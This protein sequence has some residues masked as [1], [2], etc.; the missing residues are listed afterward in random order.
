MDV[1]IS[2]KP[3]RNKKKVY[4][5]LEWGKGPGER[6]ATGIYSWN[7][8]QNQIEKNY[9]KEALAIL[10]T[11]KAEMVLDLQAAGSVH[12]RQHKIK[13]NFLDYY[14][15]HIHR[16]PS[17]IKKTCRFLVIRQVKF[18]A[19]KSQNQPSIL[20]Q[21]YHSQAPLKKFLRRLRCQMCN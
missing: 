11:K 15:E 10:E 12:I 1:K 9:N 13:A 2:S 7:K 16:N 17:V 5:Y 19:I 21:K 8:P 20:V 6:V 4:Y 14:E 3:S 18:Q